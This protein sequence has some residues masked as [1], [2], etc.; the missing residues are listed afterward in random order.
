[1]VYVIYTVT[2]QIEQIEI[3]ELVIPTQL[4]TKLKNTNSTK[5]LVELVFFGETFY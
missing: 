3:G 4:T 2:S 5:E 1:M